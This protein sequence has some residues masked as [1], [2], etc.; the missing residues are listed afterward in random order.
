MGVPPVDKVTLM[1]YNLIKP[2]DNDNKNSILDT[3]ELEAYLKNTKKYPLH[4]DI[5]LP[6]FSWSQ[7]IRDGKV[8]KLLNKMNFSH[9]ENDSNF[10][11]IQADRVLVKHPCFHG[12]YYF[13][14]ND[15][16]KIEQVTKKD[17]LEMADAIKNHSNH[18]IRNL[19]FYDLDKT[20]F[21]LYEKDIFRAV[22]RRFD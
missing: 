13:Q 5:A 14:E 10:T 22:V 3:K 15:L 18:R 17:L 9:F 1:C 7:Q 16:V 12:G 6:V 19:I 20:N 2:L 4:L 8:I 11:F 21:V